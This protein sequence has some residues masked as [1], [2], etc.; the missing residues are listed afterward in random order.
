MIE[1]SRVWKRPYYAAQSQK[2]NT[3]VGGQELALLADAD[4]KRGHLA[5]YAN[6]ER[7]IFF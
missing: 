2:Q 1:K 7:I 3:I 4:L 6:C 5:F